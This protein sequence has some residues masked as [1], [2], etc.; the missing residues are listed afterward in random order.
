M[1]RPTQPLKRHLEPNA[2]LPMRCGKKSRHQTAIKL[3]DDRHDNADD[4]ERNS[5]R[6]QTS[7]AVDPRYRPACLSAVLTILFEEPRYGALCAGCDATRSNARH[8][9]PPLSA[10]RNRA[11]IQ[12]RGRSLH[13]LMYWDLYRIMHQ[14]HVPV[15]R[16]VNEACDLGSIRSKGA[17]GMP[18]RLNDSFQFVRNVNL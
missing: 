4:S 2:C 17:L 5:E 18:H 16:R 1:T 7:Y 11:P 8:R 3:I 9:G 13:Q 6:R 10:S 15:T 14:S 12:D